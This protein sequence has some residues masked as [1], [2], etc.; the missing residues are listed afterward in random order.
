LQIL[1]EIE[2][3]LERAAGENH[4]LRQRQPFNLPAVSRP[5]VLVDLRLM[6]RG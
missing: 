1:R 3:M 6:E 4:H 2:G 5:F